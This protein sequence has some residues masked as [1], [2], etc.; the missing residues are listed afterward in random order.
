MYI[1]V[2]IK[3]NNDNV[4]LMATLPT[5][6]VSI[7]SKLDKLA[8]KMSS[9]CY[10][11]IALHEKAVHEKNVDTCVYLILRMHLLHEFMNQFEN[12]HVLSLARDKAKNTYSEEKTTKN[13]MLFLIADKNAVKMYIKLCVSCLMSYEAVVK[14]TR[15]NNT[16]NITHVFILYQSFIESLLRK[17]DAVKNT[18]SNQCSKRDDLAKHIKKMYELFYNENV[19]LVTARVTADIANAHN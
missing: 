6:D 4:L 11:C 5:N 19:Q 15:C 3:L 16:T 18:K 12:A 7:V 17:N 14:F 2:E 9:I 8:E 1:T 13:Q 10:E